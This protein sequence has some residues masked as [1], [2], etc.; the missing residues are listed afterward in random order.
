MFAPNRQASRALIIESDE[1]LTGLGVTKL[2]DYAHAG[3]PLIF[4]GG[5]PSKFEGYDQSGYRSANATISRLTSLKNVHV[6]S[7]NDGL[8]SVLASLNITPRTAVSANGTWYTFWREG[9]SVDYIYVYNDASGLP[10]GEGY[11]TGTITFESTGVPYSYNAWTGEVSPIVAYTQTSTHTTISLEL[12][13]EQTTIIGFHKSGVRPLYIES[14]PASSVATSSSASSVSI[15]NS[16]NQASTVL[17]SNGSKVTL[18]AASVSPIILT[19]WSLTVESW[20]PPSNIFD[21]NPTATRSNLTTIRNIQT[22]EPWHSL[23]SSFRTYQ[24]G[25]II[26][27][28]SNGPHTLQKEHSSTSK[29]SFILPMSASMAMLSLH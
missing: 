25:A 22:L 9:E 27:Q 1:T 8:A 19:N 21:L 29:Q 15:L 3:L 12:A 18:P 6:T 13:G 23:S 28:A 26:L 10:L 11:S 5:L 4:L 14:L 16:A 17:L 7:P 24:G 20:T 2:S